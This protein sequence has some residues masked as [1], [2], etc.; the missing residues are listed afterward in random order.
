MASYGKFIKDIGQLTVINLLVTLRGLIFLPILTKSLGPESYGIWTQLSVTLTLVASIV[1]LGLP[2]ALVRF[3]AAEK[4][5]KNI[6]EGVWS[7]IF[8]TFFASLLT[9]LV[10]VIF[11]QAIGNFLQVPPLFIQLLSFIILFEG[12]NLALVTVFRA[13]QEIGKYSLFTVLS[14]TGEI[15]ERIWFPVSRT[16]G[17][18]QKLKI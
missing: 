17:I 8:V 13:F 6:Q 15:G 16:Q 1:I 9:V 2:H 4:D 3:L 5:K 14:L 7:S 18:N 10:F 11:S 12:I